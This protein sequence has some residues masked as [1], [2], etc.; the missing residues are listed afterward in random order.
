MTAVAFVGMVGRRGPSGRTRVFSAWKNIMGDKRTRLGS[1]M[2]SAR[3]R[4]GVS[5]YTNS[6]V[7]KKYKSDNMYTY[8]E[9]DSAAASGSDDPDADWP[10]IA[11]RLNG[12]S[13]YCPIG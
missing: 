11:R 12:S 3:Q 8:A 1:T 10:L 9:Y 13:G 2:G 5:I 4:K 6:R 7:L